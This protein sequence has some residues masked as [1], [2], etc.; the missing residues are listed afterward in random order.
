MALGTGCI[1]GGAVALAMG[2]IGW[3]S[4]HL[5][6]PTVI[7]GLAQR[8]ALAWTL[9]VC[10]GCGLVLALLHRR[11]PS[12]LLPELED[13]LQDLRQPAT[14]PK[15]H[16]KRAILGAAITQIGGG[17]VGP[18]ALMSRL[19][20][21][22][23]QRL[24]QGRDRA[25]GEATL[26][27][28]FGLFGAPLLG[29]AVIRG[30]GLA[31]WVPGTL[32]G[33]AGF[34]AFHGIDTATGGSLQRLPYVWPSN[35]GEDVGTLAAGLIGGG[36]GLSLGLLFQH[37]RDWLERQDL[38]DQWRWWPVL[39]GL[40]IGACMHWLPLV[41]FAGEEQIRPLLEQSY[42]HPAWLLLL[43]ALVK[44]LMLGLCLSTCWRGGIFF[45]VFVVACS[46][47]TALHQWLP[48]LGSLGS[49]CGAIT[50]AMFGVLL[51]SPLLVLVL[52]LALLQGHGA[53]GLL[54]GLACAQWLKQ[55]RRT[56]GGLPLPP[57][58][59]GSP[60]YPPPRS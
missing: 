4:Q 43:A 16:N 56:D 24:W 27:G 1:S 19:A 5:W 58:T 10:G 52:G 44:L 21:L 50:G 12:T 45:P 9:P 59:P 34:A 11:G 57:E 37:W 60:E 53:A 7:E 18:E 38:L 15:R 28:S 47:G 33:I 46:T 13:T 25:L 36:I 2:I 17:S 3:L 30:D 14:A 26:A 32:G 22:I 49:W 39:T 35:L 41:P 42:H 40:L 8:P 23:S 55:Q 29:G 54:V 51:T 48:E 31:R 20:V 6:G